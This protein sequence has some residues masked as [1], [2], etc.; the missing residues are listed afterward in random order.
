M[1]KILMI[2]ESLRFIFLPYTDLSKYKIPKV[3]PFIFHLP[4]DK[5]PDSIVCSVWEKNTGHTDHSEGQC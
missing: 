2:T 3:L 4:E 5:A 1:A